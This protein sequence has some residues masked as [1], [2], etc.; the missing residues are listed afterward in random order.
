MLARPCIAAASHPPHA[1]AVKEFP[2]PSFISITETCLSCGAT[3]QA[4]SVASTSPSASKLAWPGSGR[5]A[6]RKALDQ[7]LV[8][9]PRPRNR[10]QD[11]RTARTAMARSR[12]RAMPGSTGAQATRSQSKCVRSAAARQLG[13]ETPSRAFVCT[14]PAPAPARWASRASSRRRA[15]PNS[16]CC[17]GGL[18]DAQTALPPNWVPTQQGR[19]SRTDPPS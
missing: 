6:P 19:R 9:P 17:V 15:D 10:C 7:G 18:R 8:G 13:W 14:V 2:C 12:F 16:I 3:A 5:T 1:A 4:T 11:C